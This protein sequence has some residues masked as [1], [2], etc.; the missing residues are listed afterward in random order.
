MRTRDPIAPDVL[1]PVDE[2]TRANAVGYSIRAL[3]AED[4]RDREHA[5][6]PYN[7]S[8][9][10]DAVMLGLSHLGWPIDRIAGFFQATHGEVVDAVNRAL[11]RH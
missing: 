5:I 11:D 10:Y 2:S 3:V 7:A 1:S 4:Y 9:D 6:T 8:V